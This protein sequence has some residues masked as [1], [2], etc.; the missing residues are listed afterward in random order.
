MLCGS[1]EDVRRCGFKEFSCNSPCSKVLDC[2]VHRCVEVCHRGACP[3][4]RTRA[5]HACQCGRV[6]EERE[7]CDR[8]FQCGYPCEKRL[9]CGKHVCERGCH[10][11]DC[12]ECP[13]R[14]ERVLVGRGFMRE[15]LVM[16]LC[17]FVGLLVIRCCP[18]ATTGA[19]S[20]ATVDGAWRLVGLS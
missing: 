7:C 12:G 9:G 13:L 16:L 20:G 18:V 5:V 17:S 10:S 14:G 6:K 3:P 1:Q 11:G 4:C 19:P 8:V 15:C 2:G